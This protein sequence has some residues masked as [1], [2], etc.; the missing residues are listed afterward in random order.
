M[1]NSGKPRI[2]LENRVTSVSNTF[3]NLENF[4]GSLGEETVKDKQVQNLIQS[5]EKFDVVIVSEFMNR[6]LRIL[7]YH[8]DASLV[9]FTNSGIIS[10]YYDQVGNIVLPSVVPVLAIEMPHR[11]SFLQRLQ[12]V[13]E[14]IRSIRWLQTNAIKQNA[15][16]EKYF[17]NSPSLEEISK[18]ISLILVNSH[19]STEVTR[20]KVPC[21]IDIGGFHVK[22]PKK[23]PED[24]QQ[25]MDDAKYGAILLSFGSI[26]D[27]KM[28]APEKWREVLQM[29]SKRKETILW[30]YSG[31]LPGKPKNV[32]I[33]KWLPQQDILGKFFA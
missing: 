16:V 27:P 21:M 33:R 3:N 6:F 25:I 28:I 20:P 9:L 1:S 14:K 18:N 12:N 8:F 22:P 2:Q 11:M 13:I 26:I 31:E 15:L 19:Y 7:A 5:G 4:F 10:W 23:L 32:V 29:F 17:P 30:K 24:L